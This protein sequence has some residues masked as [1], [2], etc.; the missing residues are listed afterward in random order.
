[1]K[2]STCTRRSFLEAVGVSAAGL[3][4]PRL[5]SAGE[6]DRVRPNVL[7]IAVDDLNDWVGCM[8]GHVQVKTPN[9]DRL[10]RRGVLFE[11][12]HCAAPISNPSRAAVF[13]GMHPFHSG[14]YTN[15]DKLPRLRPDLVTI[16]RYFAAHGYYTFGGG[17]LFHG[18]KEGYPGAFAEYGPDPNKWSPLTEEEI[19]ITKEELAADGPFVRHTVDRGPGKLKAVLPLNQMPRDRNKGSARIE[20]FDWGPFDVT[21]DVMSDAKLAR[22]AVG[23]LAEN[24]SR[25]FFLGVGFYRPHQPLFAPRKYHDMYPPDAVNLPNVLAT[26]IDDLSETGRDFALRAFTS[27]LHETVVKYGQWKNAVSSYLAC[28]SFVDAQLGRVLDALDSSPYAEDTVIVLWGDH[29]WHLGEKQ[30]WGK[31]TGWERSTRVPLIVVPAAAHKPAGFEPGRRCTTPV[32]LVDLYPTLIELCQ[33]QPNGELNGTSLVPQ[34]KEP[35]A[36]SNRPVI[37]T[38]GRGNHSVRT[39]RWRYMRYYDGSEE[40]YDHKTDPDEWH[41]L[42]ARPEHNRIKSRLARLLPENPEVAHF[43]R[44]GKWKAVIGRR[45]DDTMLFDLVAEN[46]VGEQNNVV[47]DHPDVIARIRSYIETH[48]VTSKYVTI[49]AG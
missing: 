40:L 4:C 9:I 20:S 8:A 39:N 10:A 12:A 15:S 2:T 23:K 11:N 32:S 13:T 6:S 34:L 31:Y 5:L 18:G 21:D 47:R 43:V 35:R 48:R 45:D 29:G 46:R 49:P 33:L 19:R 25:P 3:A 27:G 22:W 17:K 41:N 37:T 26:D 44:M 16:P 1:M 14:I 24:H 7:F 36:V 38:F 30:H 42:A 28:V